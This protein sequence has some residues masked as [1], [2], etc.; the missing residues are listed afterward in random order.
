MEQGDSPTEG[1]WSSKEQRLIETPLSQA[2]GMEGNGKE[3]INLAE[4]RMLF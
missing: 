1:K 4:E 3:I 2:S